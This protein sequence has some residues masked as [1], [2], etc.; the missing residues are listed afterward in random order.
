MGGQHTQ[1]FLHTWKEQELLK[2]VYFNLIIFI[3]VKDQH[4]FQDSKIFS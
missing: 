3:V 2:E 1:S 4:H